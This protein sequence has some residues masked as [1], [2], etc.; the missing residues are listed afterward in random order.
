MAKFSRKNLSLFWWLGSR[1]FNHEPCIPGVP[2]PILSCFFSLLDV[3]F[4]SFDSLL[5]SQQF[6]IYVGT[7]LPGLNQYYK[8]GIIHVFCS[9]GQ[10]SAAGEART[11]NLWSWVKHSTTEPL[12]SLV[13]WM[14]LW[15]KLL[16]KHSCLLILLLM[17]LWGLY[18]KG[19]V[20]SGLTLI[21]FAIFMSW[22]NSSEVNY[23]KN[24]CK[25]TT[26]KDQKFV[27]KTNYHLMQVI[28]QYFWPSLSYH[29]S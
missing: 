28:L 23:S 8:Q 3:L 29:L 17:C 26:L 6:F 2:C 20:W 25:T 4:V 14:W 5:P 19:A 13:C 9:R 24:L 18:Y 21:V 15:P 10:H 16:V 11:A 22:W 27:F 7:G 1:Y 12:G